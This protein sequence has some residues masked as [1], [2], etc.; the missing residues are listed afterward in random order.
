MSLAILCGCIAGFVS[1]LVG[2]PE[3]RFSDVAAHMKDLLERLVSSYFTGM[4]RD[5][6]A[7]RFANLSLNRRQTFAWARKVIAGAAN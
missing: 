4:R 5:C 7:N 2:N 1:D 3:D 6:F